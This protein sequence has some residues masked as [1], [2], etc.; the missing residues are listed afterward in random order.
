MCLIERG[1]CVDAT[2]HAR[3]RG[4][5][6]RTRAAPTWRRIYILY[7]YIIVSINGLQ[8]SLYGKGY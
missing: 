6:T 1:P 3:P 7:S 4:S 5:T 2:W 8:P